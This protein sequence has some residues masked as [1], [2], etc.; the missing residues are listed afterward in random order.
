MNLGCYSRFKES[1]DT[2]A[3]KF[4]STSP[5]CSIMR[6]QQQLPSTCLHL[7]LRLT[8]DNSF[9]CPL[10]T[11]HRRIQL[12]QAFFF[13]LLLCPTMQVMVAV[14]SPIL[15][16]AALANVGGW[17]GLESVGQIEGKVDSLRVRLGEAP[18]SNHQH[19]GLATVNA[20]EAEQI[21]SANG[22]QRKERSPKTQGM[23]IICYMSL[24][25]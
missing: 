16:Q 11:F 20:K 17:V 13:F 8:A 18:S 2:L 12:A 21:A 5:W 6:T 22:V 15:V 23:L 10:F 7:F 1:Q 19:G 14:R 3:I 24:Q 4:D 25:L 9:F